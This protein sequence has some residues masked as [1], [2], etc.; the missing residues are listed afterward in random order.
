MRSMT[1]SI[2]GEEQPARMISGGEP[3]AS[4]IECPS[5]AHATDARLR[6][7]YQ[8]ENQALLVNAVP[9]D[10]LALS[11]NPSLNASTDFT[12]VLKCSF[13]VLIRSLFEFCVKRTFACLL[14]STS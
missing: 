14:Q 13:M 1:A 8:C 11:T 9:E 2:S 4:E 10:I 5:C 3:V 7:N 6:A 12:P